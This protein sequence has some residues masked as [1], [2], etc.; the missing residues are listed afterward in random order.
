[1]KTLLL[2]LLL[3]QTVTYS[4]DAKCTDLRSHFDRLLCFH[5]SVEEQY[6]LLEQVHEQLLVTIKDSS[7]KK[8]F[9]LQTEFWSRE[10]NVIPNPCLRNS[11]SCSNEHLKTVTL[12]DERIEL[13]QRIQ[14]DNSV[15]IKTAMNYSYIAP[16][17]FKQFSR[18]LIG[19]TV[20]IRGLLKIPNSDT[21]LRGLI[22]SRNDSTISVD[23]LFKSMPESSLNFIQ[24][25]RPISH[26]TG[27]VIDHEGRVILYMDKILGMS[28]P[29]PEQKIVK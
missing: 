6:E 7:L 19:K 23:V 12:I 18:E 9:I 11:D 13:L 25:R 2:I 17:Y 28:L 15:I 24:D 10:R 21:P 22:Q 5:T 26:F 4:Q 16:S 20:K 1:M 3:L 8:I 27:E 14:E 29:E